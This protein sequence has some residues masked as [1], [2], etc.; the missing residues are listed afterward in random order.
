MDYCLPYPLNINLLKRLLFTVQF[1]RTGILYAQCQHHL[2][3][4][5]GSSKC[6]KCTNLH[7]L[8]ITVIV[9]VAGIVLVVFS[10]SQSL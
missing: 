1:N 7:I 8:I 9:T 2:S 4:V 5:F 6:M 10:I 3:M